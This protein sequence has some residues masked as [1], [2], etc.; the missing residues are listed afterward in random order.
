[1]V[2]QSIKQYMRLA[3]QEAKLAVYDGEVPVGAII[4]SDSGEELARAHN[5]K[6]TKK[7]PCLHA[8]MIAIAEAAKK[9]DRWRL[10]G[11]SIYVTLE[12]CPMC[13]SALQ[14]ARVKTVYFG[15]YDFKGG[16]ISLGYNLH[17]DT[18]LNH[19][20][21]VVG[22]IDNFEC[23]KLLSDFFKKKRE[24]HKKIR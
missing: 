24:L 13:L 14:Q 12:P 5:L 21:N 7:N 6:E 3:I 1:M 23:S 11:A 2:F 9:M 20:M 16:A 18:R 8:E 19:R 15:A 17:N 10:L 22:G 4:V